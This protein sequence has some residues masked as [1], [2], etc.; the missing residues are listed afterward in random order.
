MLGLD[1]GGFAPPSPINLSWQKLAYRR[2]TFANFTATILKIPYLFLAAHGI[3]GL[4]SAILPVLIALMVTQSL[5]LQALASCMV[6]SAG[7]R[8]LLTPLLAPIVDQSNPLRLLFFCNLAFAALSL[9]AAWFVGESAMG[10]THWGAYFIISA[11]IQAFEGS[12]YPKI[13]VQLVEHKRLEEFTGW[14]YAVL[15]SARL[16]GPVI[17]GLCLLAW[18]PQQSL[19]LTLL[20]PPFLCLPLYAL[21]LLRLGERF[22]RKPESGPAKQDRMSEKV[23]AWGRDVMGGFRLRWAVRTERYL[24]IQIFLELLLIIPSFGILLPSVLQER[25]WSNSWLAWLE[26]GSGAGLVLG[27]VLAP[28]LMRY[29]GQWRVSLT[30]AFLLALAVA[31]CALFI[32]QNLPLALVFALF[33]ANFMLALRI[34]GGAAQR[35]VAVPDRMRAQFAGAHITLNALAAQIGISVAALWVAHFAIATWFWFCASALFLLACSMIFIPGYRHLVQ[36]EV[37]QAAGFYERQY[38]SVFAA[39]KDE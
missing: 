1:L 11:M 17:A 35:R 7:V 29:C 23:R 13:S 27:S 15:Y 20:L 12:A 31:C 14:E 39:G 3:A 21:L 33:C 5:S 25:R 16:G 6:I 19:L 18:S 36:M 34:Q 2:P 38:P 26:A 32:V 28:K 24:S 4:A 37:A 30:A 8:L 9:G 22:K 10:I